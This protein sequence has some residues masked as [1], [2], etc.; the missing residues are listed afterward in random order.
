MDLNNKITHTLK[1]SD[2]VSRYLSGELSQVEQD[3]LEIWINESSNN[4]ILFEELCH[5][6]NLDNA[7]EVFN[8]FD[9]VAALNKVKTNQIFNSEVNKSQRKLW[10]RIGFAAAILLIIGSLAVSLNLFKSPNEGVRTAS[11]Y[12]DYIAPGNAGATLTLANGKKIKL[13]G[14]INGKIANEAGVVITKSND[15][16][17][18]YEIKDKNVANNKINTLSTA[19]GETYQI[20]LPDGSLVALNAASS[21]TYSTSLN[22]RGERRVRLTGEAYFEV[23]E[24]KEHPFV[25]ESKG[26][27]VKVLGT[28][29][30][31][32][33]YDDEAATKTTLLKG[34]VRVNSEVLLPNEQSI[35]NGDGIKVVKVNV[36]PVVAWKDG[37]FVFKDTSLDE[38]LRQLSRWYDIEIKYSNGIPKRSFTGDIS[39]SLNLS[40]A[41]DILKYLKVSFKIEGRS[42]TVT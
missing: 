28:K 6:Q 38:V 21:L 16:Q 32:N 25:V 4:R 26:Q 35:I 41:L 33:A 14:A 13:S 29:F 2:L 36:N 39:R 9:E 1:V 40:D 7:Y 30:N 15:G 37:R 27:E 10:P 18:I 42:L 22:E 19:K 12:E 11:T 5:V 17:L 8:R 34:R 31:I 24:D 20:R 3:E 23:F